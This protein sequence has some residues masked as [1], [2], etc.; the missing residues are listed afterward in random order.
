[1]WIIDFVI[2]TLKNE[3]PLAQIAEQYGSVLIIIS[4]FM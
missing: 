1:M 3:T 4:L 2:G